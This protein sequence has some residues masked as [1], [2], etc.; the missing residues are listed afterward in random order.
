[1]PAT[2]LS[3]AEPSQTHAAVRIAEIVGS[4]SP[5]EIAQI[6]EARFQDAEDKRARDSAR[7]IYE[8]AYTR[9]VNARDALRV[10]LHQGVP[11]IKPLPNGGFDGMV[12]LHQREVAELVNAYATQSRLL[13]EAAQMVCDI[14]ELPDDGEAVGI[15][16]GCPL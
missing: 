2:Q 1:M 11:T 16:W 3:P 10:R 15:K 12:G 9:A 4:L 13:W 7:L 5:A 8:R 14:E 6:P